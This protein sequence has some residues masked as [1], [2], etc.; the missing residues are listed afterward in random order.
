MADFVV[1]TKNAAQI[2]VRHENCAGPSPP[3]Q[4]ILFAKVWTVAR[5]YCLTSRLAEAQFT[6]QPIDL[7]LP[8]AKTA[9][10]KNRQSA[11]D[12]FLKNGI[13]VGFKV[14]RFHDLSRRCKLKNFYTNL[15]RFQGQTSQLVN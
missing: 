15:P 3:N 13:F 8:R 12:S 1:L 5:N 11:F 7:A 4:G 10:S 2:A 14:T 9:V 6:F